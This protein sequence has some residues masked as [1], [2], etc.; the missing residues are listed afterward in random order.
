MFNLRQ[1]ML[2]LLLLIS[3]SAWADDKLKV[4]HVGAPQVGPAIILTQALAE[5]LTVPYEFVS[6]KDCAGALRVIEQE[7]NVLFV[8][9]EITN[10]TGI[11]QNEDCIPKQWRPRDIV[12][13]TVSSWDLCKKAGSNA[14]IGPNK[15]SIGMVSVLPVTGIVDDFNKL[16]GTNAVGV[17][18]PSSIQV[19]TALV[20]GDLQWGMV[21]PG[22]SRPAMK[23]GTLECPMTFIPQGSDKIPK[24][25]FIGNY[26]KMTVPFLRSAYFMSIKS[27]DTKIRIDVDKAVNSTKFNEFLIKTGYVGTKTGLGNFSNADIDEYFSYVNEVVTKLYS[28]PAYDWKKE[29]KNR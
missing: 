4:L 28:L 25:K 18:L 27:T 19:T 23:E 13:Y 12:G 3:A 20:N 11:R 17:A 2:F 1:T 16:N 29:F 24:E 8:T 7:K 15:F 26:Y 9:Q 10:I 22:M 14:K 6:M 5:N 21:S